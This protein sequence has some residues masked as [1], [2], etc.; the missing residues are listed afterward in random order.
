MQQNQKDSIAMSF[1]IFPVPNNGE[2]YISGYFFED[3]EIKIVTMDGKV[4]YSDRLTES[5]NSVNIKINLKSGSYFVFVLSKTGEEIY[6]GKITII[7]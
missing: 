1:A 4:V 5:T 6:H 2:F 3:Y 7:N